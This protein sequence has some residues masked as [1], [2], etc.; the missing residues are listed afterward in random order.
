MALL[1]LIIYIGVY[2]LVL[3]EFFRTQFGWG[4]EDDPRWLMSDV[5]L[6]DSN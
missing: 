1:S 6:L 5:V 3:N 2:S 4:I